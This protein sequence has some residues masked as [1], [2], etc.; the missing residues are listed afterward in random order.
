M[1]SWRDGDSDGLPNVV[2]EAMACGL[3]VIGTEAGSL[4]D[5]LTER[6][7]FIAESDLSRGAFK[8][9]TPRNLALAIREVLLEPERARERAERA[10]NVVEEL[11][12]IQK[13]IE[14]L[15]RELSVTKDGG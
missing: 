13:N 10:R 8:L 3:P 4:G 15:F 12:D 6:T 11:Y 9:T 7:G 5:V 1:S 14:P 2:L